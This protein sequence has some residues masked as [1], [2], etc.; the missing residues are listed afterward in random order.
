[1]VTGVNVVRGGDIGYYIFYCLFSTLQVLRPK[2]PAFYVHLAGNQTGI[3][4]RVVAFLTLPGK[5]K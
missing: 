3:N 4:D 1:L 5:T 2:L